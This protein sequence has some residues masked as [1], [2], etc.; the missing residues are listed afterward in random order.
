VANVLLEVKS[1]TV[2]YRGALALHGVSLDVAPGESVSIVGPNGAGKTSLLRAISGL[3][4]CQ[5]EV[6]LDGEVITGLSPERVVRRGL[7]HCPQA[8]QL[9]PEMTVLE[10]LELGSFTVRDAAARREALDRVFELFPRVAERKAQRAGTLSGGERQMVAI[11]RSLMG[12]PRL[13]MLDEPSLGLAPLMRDRIEEAIRQVHRT[14]GLTVILVEQ[15]TAFAMDIA[16]RVY[17]LD[18]GQVVR[19][20][21]VAEIAGD[22]AIRRAYLGVA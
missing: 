8:A 13:L 10:N 22:P 9:F 14:W 1:L 18:G 17:V 15:D 3:V 7:V 11:G 4:P 5:G 21:P 16:D 20:G 12:R 19:H 6:R 2:S